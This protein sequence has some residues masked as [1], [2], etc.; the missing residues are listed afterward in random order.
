MHDPAKYVVPVHGVLAALL[1]VA[2]LQAT[3]AA[4]E[5]IDEIAI[6]RH[7]SM[8]RARLRLTTPVHYIRDYISKE[9]KI[10]IVYLQALAPQ[11]IGDRPVPDEVKRSPR[12]ALVP[13]FTV[14][15]NR[16]PRCE[17]APNPVCMVIQFDR[18]VRCQI[19]LG[20]DRRSL[21]LDFPLSEEEG[22]SPSAGKK[23]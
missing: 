8:A 12:N 5:I 11:A 13:R 21:L 14:R 2:L 20:E 15:V 1:V 23:N 17:P 10:V 7:D 9:G 16:D 4:G 3:P 19:R 22:R 6:E 18:S